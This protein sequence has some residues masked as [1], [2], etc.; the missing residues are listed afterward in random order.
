MWAEAGQDEAR[1]WVQTPASFRAVVAGVRRRLQREREDRLVLAHE[2][3]AL[4]GAAHAG[5]L[6]DVDH[7]LEKI[8]P[9]TRKTPEQLLRVLQ[10]AAA[11]GAP[12]TIRRV[13]REG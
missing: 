4:G 9:R 1:F 10:D 7:Y 6:Q 13:R 11:R 3:A 2:T 12:M 5:K 8:R